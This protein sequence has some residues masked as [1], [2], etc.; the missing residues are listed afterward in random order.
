VIG[1]RQAEEAVV[2]TAAGIPA[3]YACT[4]SELDAGS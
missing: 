3:F 1:K 2:H 4:A